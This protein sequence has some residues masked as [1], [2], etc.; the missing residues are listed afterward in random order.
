VG[1]TTHYCWRCYATNPEP[2]GPCRSCGGPIEQPASATWTDQLI[3]ALG[4]PLPGRQMIAAQV[5]GQRREIRAAAPLRVLVG[6]ADP[7]LAA[8]A[9]QSLVLILGADAIGDMLNELARTGAPAV[10]RVAQR[11]LERG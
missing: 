8:Q 10:S 1:S 7:Y 2:V 9:L 4:H 5:L 11:A 3:W 6:N